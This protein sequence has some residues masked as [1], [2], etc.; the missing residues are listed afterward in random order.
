MRLTL[1]SSLCRGQDDTTWPKVPGRQTL[2]SG[3]TF[4]GLRNELGKE[5]IFIWATLI[6]HCTQMFKY[7]Y[8]GEDPRTHW[9]KV[10]KCNRERE[11][12]PSGYLTIQPVPTVG[13]RSS[14]LLGEFWEPR[15]RSEGAGVFIYQFPLVPSGRLLLV[16]VL[17]PQDPPSAYGQSRAK[18]SRILRPE[19]LLRQRHAGGGTRRRGQRAGSGWCEGSGWG[20]NSPA[21]GVS[22]SFFFPSSHAVKNS[23]N[24]DC[25]P[26]QWQTLS[27]ARTVR[28]SNGKVAKGKP[29][30]GFYPLLLHFPAISLG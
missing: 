5:Q 28:S 13:A 11:G 16:G 24:C 4:Q 27:H 1:V 21:T 14:C 22:Y 7:K 12:S 17:T 6:L 8:L 10:D 26:T 9:G 18:Q 23:L 15:P 25:M 2:L 20:T 3:G 29:A 19:K 30:S